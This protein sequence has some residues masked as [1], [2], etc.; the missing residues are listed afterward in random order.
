[1]KKNHCKSSLFI[2]FLFTIAIFAISCGGGG[3]G[4]GGTSPPPP[5]QNAPSISNLNY[6]PTSAFLNDGGGLVGVD[7]TFDFNDPNGNISTVTISVFDMRGNQIDTITVPVLGVSGDTSGTIMGTIDADTTVSGL[8]SFQMYVSDA[9]GLQ[10][11]ILSGTFPI[12]IMIASNVAPPNSD[13]ERPGRP[14]IGYDGNNYLVVYCKT[15]GTTDTMYGTLVSKTGIIIN[16]FQISDTGSNRSAVAF[17]GTNYLVV[18]GTTSGSIMGQR[19]STAG[20][21]MDGITGFSISTIDSNWSPAIAYDG[22]NYMVVWQKFVNNIAYDIYGTKITPVG[23][24]LGEFAV[25][26]RSGEQVDPAIAFD[27]TNYFVVWQDTF[28][29]SYPSLDTHIY[30]TRIK[31]DGTVLD[32]AGIPVVT[33]LGLQAYSQI[34]YDGTNYFAVWLQKDNLSPTAMYSIFGKRIAKD[35]TLI[36][37]TASQEG[38]AINT[39]SYESKGQPSVHFDGTQ[40]FVVWTYLTFP[41]YTPAGIYGAKVSTL[42]VL[43]GS[44]DQA[45]LPISGTPPNASRYAYPVAFY[46]GVNSLLVWANVSEMYGSPKD[47]RGILL[48]P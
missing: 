24:V 46:S 13:T 33:A 25:T 32:V 18:F 36:D 40:Y 12:H 15:I 28:S 4:G 30:G 44:P 2:A 21:V 6:S 35:G 19:V 45:G 27:G 7:V 22:A 43:E 47:I 1:M 37:G 16:S 31:P 20:V 42:G 17:D 3:G 48:S 41:N 39:S 34:T 9:T 14:S 23:Q 10:S 8:F 11:N 26:T 38:I 5:P 29:G